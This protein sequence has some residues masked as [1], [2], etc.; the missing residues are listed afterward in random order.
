MFT[1]VKCNSVK[2]HIKFLKADYASEKQ[3]IN[4]IIFLFSVYMQYYFN[5]VTYYFH[6]Y[7]GNFKLDTVTSE[8]L[9]VSSNSYYIITMNMIYE[10]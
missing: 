4:V 6:R 1:T 2:V 3:N 9:I 10:Y 8:Y 7:I 5:V